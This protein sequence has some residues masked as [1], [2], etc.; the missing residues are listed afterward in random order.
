MLFARATPETCAALLGRGRRC[1]EE[2]QHPQA[3]GR[4]PQHKESAM[5]RTILTTL[6]DDNGGHPLLI[7]REAAAYYV[8]TVS[9]RQY[10]IPLANARYAT[11]NAAHTRLEQEHRQRHAGALQR[12]AMTMAEKPR[13]NA[14]AALGILTRCT[15]THP[16]AE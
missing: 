11:Y 16:H 1:S 5:P 7:Y 10:L 15:Q 8:G 4:A 12:G 6:P 14:P 13:L 2:Y 3:P 9:T